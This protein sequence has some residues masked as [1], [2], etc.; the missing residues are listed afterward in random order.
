M[1]VVCQLCAS[2]MAG[3]VP[4]RRRVGSL[5]TMGVR[6][7]TG[8]LPVKVLFGWFTFE[9]IAVSHFLQTAVRCREM[10]V[11]AFKSLCPNEFRAM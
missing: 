8:R 3:D 2:F 6:S 9:V 5:M 1:P 10:A 11:N 4:C 7:A